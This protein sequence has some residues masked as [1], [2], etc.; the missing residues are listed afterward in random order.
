[1]LLGPHMGLFPRIWGD[2]EINWIIKSH[3]MLTAWTQIILQLDMSLH[4]EGE[5]K[6]AVKFGI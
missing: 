1:M 5:A 2:Y 3:I 6:T 4:L